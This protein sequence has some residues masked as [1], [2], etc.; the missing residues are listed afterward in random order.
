[1]LMLPEAWVSFAAGPR[2]RASEDPSV[3]ADLPELHLPQPASDFME[4]DGSSNQAW[5]R[6]LAARPWDV[7]GKVEG[8]EQAA[9]GQVHWVDQPTFDSSDDGVFD[10]LLVLQEADTS[11]PDNRGRTGILT[12]PSLIDCPRRWTARDYEP[13]SR[14]ALRSF[15]LVSRLAERACTYVSIYIY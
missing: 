2:L 14:I 1:M 9:K 5:L 7:H 10:F 15:F 3:A 11:E 13:C 4:F 6:P 12:R 8:D